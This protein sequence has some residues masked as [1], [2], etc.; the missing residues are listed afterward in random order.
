MAAREGRV[1]LVDMLREITTPS[2]YEAN[3]RLVLRGQL[4]NVVINRRGPMFHHEPAPTNRKNAFHISKLT[5]ALTGH[6]QNAA[7]RV[8]PEPQQ[9]RGPVQRVG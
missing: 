7:S 4:Q 9:G 5:P 3:P 2:G 6:G 1:K 8:S